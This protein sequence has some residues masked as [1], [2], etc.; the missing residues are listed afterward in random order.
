M[1]IMG[2]FAINAGYDW[3]GHSV[4]SIAKVAP[5]NSGSRIKSIEHNIRL[6]VNDHQKHY[7][8]EKRRHPHTAISN[9]QFQIDI[10]QSHKK[11]MVL[12]S[13]I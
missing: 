7:R 13:S 8:P 11:Q 2:W 10:E 3:L 12:N 6:P 1:Y 5:I 4:A 9:Q